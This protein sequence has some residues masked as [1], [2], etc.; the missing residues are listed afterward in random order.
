MQK[1]EAGNGQKKGKIVRLKRAHVRTYK[2]LIAACVAAL[3]L[4]TGASVFF[5]L[6]W[7]DAADQY[8]AIRAEK[9]QYAQDYNFVK[10]E[11]EKMIGEML[12]LSSPA[13]N[14]I[15]LNAKDSTKQYMARVY[16]NKYTRETY[17]YVHDLPPPA[18]DKQYQLWALAGGQPIDAG[19]FN[20]NDEIGMQKV[21]LINNA[22]A[23]AVTLEPKGGSAVPTMDQMYLIS[24]I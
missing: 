18:P 14:I 4:S 8:V 12:V 21:K 15:T 24:K 7:S 13:M 23:W 5:F 22:D 20:M 17:V 10:L 1:I 2:Y 16:W 11:N 3:I 9:N 19:V 6:K